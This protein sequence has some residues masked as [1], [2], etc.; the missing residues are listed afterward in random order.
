MNLDLFTLTLLAFFL[1]TFVA[2]EFEFRRLARRLARLEA[3]LDLVFRE[4][5]LSWKDPVSDRVKRILQKKGKVAAINAQRQ[6]VGGTTA[7]AANAV[8]VLEKAIENVEDRPTT[9]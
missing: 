3:K 7:E 1:V 4:L 9:D 5:G 2:L 8:E 6:E